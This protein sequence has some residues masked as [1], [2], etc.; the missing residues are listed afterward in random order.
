[1]APF[2]AFLTYLRS[3]NLSYPVFTNCI[4]DVQRIRLSLSVMQPTGILGLVLPVSLLLHNGLEALVDLLIG[5]L[6]LWIE[7]CPLLE[8]GLS[9]L[10]RLNVGIQLIPNGTNKTHVI[11]CTN[12]PTMFVI[13]VLTLL[14]T[15]HTCL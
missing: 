4:A 8:V 9:K 13:T 5:V 14:P 10:I 11:T 15:L 3:L 1:M 6:W 2:I 7:S 12:K